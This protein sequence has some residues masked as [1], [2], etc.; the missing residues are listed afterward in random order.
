MPTRYI[1]LLR[2]INVGKAKRVAMVDLRALLENLGFENVRTLLNSGNVVFS[3]VEKLVDTEIAERIEAAFA[4]QFGFSS[5]LTVLTGNEL[6][7]VVEANPLAGV[8]KE[9]SRYLIAFLTNAAD[10]KKLDPLTQRDWSPEALAL[11][12]RAAYLWCPDG[13]LASALPEAVG[14]ALKDGVTTRNWATV[15]KLH[16]LASDGS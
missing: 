12:R 8:A 1:G 11:G 5:R 15:L 3:S 4:K 6:T 7:E 13:V 14:Q 2:G 16:A 10:R 9:P